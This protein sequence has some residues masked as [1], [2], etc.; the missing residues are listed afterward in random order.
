MQGI[1]FL[2]KFLDRTDMYLGVCKERYGGAYRAIVLQYREN[3]DFLFAWID[4][5]RF[6]QASEFFSERCFFPSS[7][8]QQKHSCVFTQ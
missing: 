3:V 7:W 8:A 1:E 6:S 4:M 5:D 2:E